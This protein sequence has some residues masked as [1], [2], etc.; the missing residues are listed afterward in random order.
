MSTASEAWFKC[1]DPESEWGKVTLEGVKD[2][3]DLKKAIK[4]EMAPELDAYPTSRLTIKA[5]K[6]EHD[7][8]K[9]AVKLEVT[10]ELASAL[11]EY[12]TWLLV[13]VPSVQKKS[14]SPAVPNYELNSSLG[15]P[16]DDLAQFWQSLRDAKIDEQNCITLPNGT[17]WAGVKDFGGKLYIRDAYNTLWAQISNPS[18][19]NWVITGTPGIGKTYF[20]LF[21]LYKIRKDHPNDIVLRQT[22]DSR[23]VF[24]PDGKAFQVE[25]FGN[26]F[27]RNDI[28]HLLDAVTLAETSNGKVVI[29]TSPKI[30]EW[31]G[32]KPPLY[33]FRYMPTWSFHELENWNTEFQPMGKEISQENLKELYTKWGGVPRTL[34]AVTRPTG[35]LDLESLFEPNCV[36][37]CFD[38]EAVPTYRS[39]PVGNITGK[40]LHVIPMNDELYIPRVCFATTYIR[41]RCLSVLLKHNTL[42]L[43]QILSGLEVG[44]LRGILFE[45]FS[46]KILLRGGKFTIYQLGDRSG[47]SSSTMDIDLPAYTVHHFLS[48]DPLMSEKYNMPI[49]SN[50]AT[51]DAIIPPHFLFQ[52]TTSDTHSIKWLRTPNRI[53]S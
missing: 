4:K 32:V 35:L 38:V 20:S 25:S 2:I 52:M 14:N 31:K 27:R 53:L 51:V 40:L 18:V 21:L 42:Q 34:V 11:K 39:L 19:K 5:K 10:E 41:E 15:G 29:V 49:A 37:N 44:A 1:I 17:Y 16:G 26:L 30:T 9:E 13:Y 3:Y 24:Y 46:H 22:I 12:G 43:Q 28:W 45:V 6:G 23:Q 7:D 48:S 36:A 47:D 33:D 8:D 50:N